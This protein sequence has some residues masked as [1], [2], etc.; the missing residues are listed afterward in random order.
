MCVLFVFVIR[1]ITCISQVRTLISMSG[2]RTVNIKKTENLELLFRD[3]C[4]GVRKKLSVEYVVQLKHHIQIP[5]W[6]ECTMCKHANTSINSQVRGYMG[7]MRLTTTDGHLDAD[8]DL[9]FHTNY[10]LA[11]PPPCLP[12]PCPYLCVCTR[13]TQ[14]RTLAHKHLLQQTQ[15]STKSCSH[16]HT[17]ANT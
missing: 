6:C 2:G 5:L 7:T 11:P 4:R 17:R 8:L 14:R 13:D 9:G 12:P 16:T 3:P 15:S 10:E 1:V